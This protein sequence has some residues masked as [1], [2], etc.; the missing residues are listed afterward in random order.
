[1]GKPRC[2]NA[3]RAWRQ[4]SLTPSSASVHL[5]PAEFSKYELVLGFVIISTP[6]DSFGNFASIIY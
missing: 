2:W 1:M 6:P 4:S 5:I 3:S